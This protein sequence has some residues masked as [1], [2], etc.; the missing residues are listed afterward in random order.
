MANKI[1]V[2]VAIH[3][4]TGPWAVVRR[5]VKWQKNKSNYMP[6]VFLYLR[7]DW[8]SYHLKQLKELGVGFELYSISKWKLRTWYFTLYFSKELVNYTNNLI[9]H[10]HPENIIIHFHT[11]MLTGLFLPFKVSS[12]SR[13]SL[14]TTFHGAIA[15]HWESSKIRNIVHKTLMKKTAK[16]THLISVDDFS[17]H[18]LAKYL[19]TKATDFRIIHNGVPKTTVRGCPGARDPRVPLTAGFVGVLNESKGWRLAADAVA[20]LASEGLPIRIVFAGGGAQAHQLKEWTVA[21]Q[22]IARF[23]GYVNDVYSEL[24]P[25]LDV[26]VLPSSTE[27]LPVAVLEAMSCG[28]PSIATPVGGLPE[29]IEHEKTG[30]LVKRDVVDIAKR[31]SFLVSNRKQLKLMSEC[32]IDRHEKYFSME[33]CGKSYEQTYAIRL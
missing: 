17:P 29:L 22:T 16:Y 5:L 18:T 8:P 33:Q 3:P 12:S 2:H 13:L 27:G 14:V 10:Y 32:C 4:L 28:I 23:K 26:L 7:K 25:D 20:K 24:Y 6:F 15:M 19:G 9:N 30:F 21:N 31:L 1:V 11:N